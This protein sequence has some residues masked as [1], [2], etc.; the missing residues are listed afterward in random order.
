MTEKSV[1][2]TDRSATKTVTQVSRFHEGG[3]EEWQGL[4]RWEVAP[5]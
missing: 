5:G 4:H 1:I 2:M 3:Q